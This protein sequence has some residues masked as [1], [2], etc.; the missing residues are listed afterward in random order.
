MELRVIASSSEGNAYV[1]QNEGEALLIEAGA[2]FDQ[3]LEALGHNVAKVNGCLITHEHGDHA[4][5]ISEVLSYGLPV[6][7]SRGTIREIE[8]KLRSAYKPRLIDFDSDGNYYPLQLGRFEVYPFAT[9]HDAAEPLGFYIWH[10]ETGGILFATDTY[11]IRPTFDD[12]RQVII[13]CNYADDL[14]AANVEKNVRGLTW[15]LAQRIR[16]SHLSLE[17]CLGAL[18]ANDLR[19]VN[20]VVLIHVSASNGDPARFKR[21]VEKATGRPTFIA[22]PGLQLNININPF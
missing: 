22:R 3:T 8:P 4:A 21:E 5:H 20:N 14:L 2:H 11:Y 16:A 18:K 13:E 12:L 19:K 9:K 1:I 15:K 17:T 10:P 7:A 6:Y